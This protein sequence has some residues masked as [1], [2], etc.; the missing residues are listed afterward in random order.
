MK[1]VSGE[2]AAYTDVLRRLPRDAVEQLAAYADALPVVETLTVDGPLG[3][4]ARW[5][6]FTPPP[7]PMRLELTET[8][9]SGAILSTLPHGVWWEGRLTFMRPPGDD[10]SSVLVANH[11]APGG[12]MRQDP[13]LSRCMGAWMFQVAA[14]DRHMQ[15][16]LFATPELHAAVPWISPDWSAGRCVVA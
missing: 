10:G 16:R 3:L 6:F 13:A 9:T 14:V 12:K 4:V 11:S 1:P 15:L 5:E 7:V 2:D 8:E